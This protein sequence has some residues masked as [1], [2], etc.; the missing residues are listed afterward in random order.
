MSASRLMCSRVWPLRAAAR[1][2][3]IA[4]T[5]RVEHRC[6]GAFWDPNRVRLVFLVRRPSSVA[7][8]FRRTGGEGRSPIEHLHDGCQRPGVADYLSHPRSHRAIVSYETDGQAPLEAGRIALGS[9]LWSGPV[10]HEPTS[11]LIGNR[12]VKADDEVKFN[13]RANSRGT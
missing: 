6:C 3:W 4:L 7:Q 10:S 1:S 13:T 5:I 9:P 2:S 8:S 12:F 11:G